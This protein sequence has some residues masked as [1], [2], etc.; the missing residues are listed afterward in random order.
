M[1]FQ[2]ETQFKLTAI[3]IPSYLLLVTDSTIKLVRWDAYWS[4]EHSR[5]YYHEPMTNTTTWTRPPGMR[6][7]SQSPSSR[8]PS[9]APTESTSIL[10]DEVEVRD[11]TTTGEGGSITP[12]SVYRNARSPGESI[13]S[14][15][16]YEDDRVTSRPRD[17]NLEFRPD[18]GIASNSLAQYRLKQKRRRRR[19]RRRAAVA[20]ALLVLVMMILFTFK[21]TELVPIANEM[22]G[23]RIACAVIPFIDE[24]TAIKYGLVEAPKTPP[25]KKK[26]ATKPP[27]TKKKTVATSES[28]TGATSKTIPRTDAQKKEEPKANDPVDISSKRSQNDKLDT[29][30][31]E[32]RN[33]NNAK[34]TAAAL[35]AETEKMMKRRRA[36]CNIPLMYILYRPCWRESRSLPLD[37]SFLESTMQ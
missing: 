2:R 5:E 4:T 26:A 14:D 21:G 34:S 19:R 18:S 31:A 12:N 35:N 6:V 27:M 23:G 28:T 32:K 13:L 36:I 24:S 7:D 20:A 16:T 15:V 30:Q 11:F 25:V 1:I 9:A 3:I 17:N 37:M 10:S 29:K 8:N 22:S 33:P